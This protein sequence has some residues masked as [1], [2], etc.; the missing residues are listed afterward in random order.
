MTPNASAQ[1]PTLAELLCRSTRKS[2]YFIKDL[3]KARRATQFIGQGSTQSSTAAYATAAGALANTGQYADTDVV[4]VSAEGDRRGRFNPIAGTPQGAYRTLDLAIAAR[5][6]FV[7]DRQGDRERPYNTGE[8]QVASYLAGR[9]YRET[10][11][12]LFCPPDTD[13]ALPQA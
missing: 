7:V 4:F 5:A 13:A 10:S 11:P 2:P 9:G 3:A 1:P 12:G 8:R 6:R